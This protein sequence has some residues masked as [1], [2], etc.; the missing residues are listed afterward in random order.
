MFAKKGI[1]TTAQSLLSWYVDF[2]FWMSVTR[3]WQY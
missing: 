2:Y 1:W 3:V